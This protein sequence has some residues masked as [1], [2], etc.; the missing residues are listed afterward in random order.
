[1][2]APADRASAEAFARGW[3]AEWNRRDIE[4]VLAHFA[5]GARFTSP[6]ALE[7]TG[8]ATVAGTEALRSYWQG[9]LKLPHLRFTLDRVVWD[10]AQRELL[11]LYTADL[12]GKKSRAMEVMRFGPDGLVHEAEAMYGVPA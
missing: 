6:R 9:A 1:M 2:S 3:I 4:A 5:P 8:Q 10:A 12:G 7:R 11:I